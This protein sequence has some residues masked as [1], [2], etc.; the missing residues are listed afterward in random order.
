MADVREIAV[1]PSALKPGHFVGQYEIV[2]WV[3][4]GG[5][6][7]VY[8]VKRDGDVYGLKILTNCFLDDDVDSEE[9]RELRARAKR[10][11]LVVNTLEH[12]NILRGLACDRWPGA[13][14]G[15]PYI[16][17]EYVDGQD[18]SQFSIRSLR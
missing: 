15:W 13:R 8:K 5:A 2:E 11:F 17:T 18:I 16:V 6:A 12:P 3:G 7:C 1:Y 10:E 14:R 4:S 9:Q